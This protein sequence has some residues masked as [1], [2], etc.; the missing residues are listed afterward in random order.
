MRT[1]VTAEILD[2]AC[3]RDGI[4]IH[5]VSIGRSGDPATWSVNFHGATAAQE[6]EAAA[7]IENFDAEVTLWEWQEVRSDRDTRLYA[8]DWTQLPD[9]PLSDADKALWSTYRQSL[10]DIP[11][12][13][14]D[15]QA[16]VWPS[17]PSSVD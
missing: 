9:S 2:N 10:R 8:C 14:G 6:L 11:A 12:N 13:Q 17:D 1:R 16:I 5:G 15:P 4:P 7:I 3:K